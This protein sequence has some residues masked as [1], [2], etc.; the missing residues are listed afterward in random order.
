MTAEEHA[1]QAKHLAIHAGSIYQEINA[2]VGAN[3]L[4]PH[5]LAVKFAEMQAVS[6]LAQVHA[7]LAQVPACC[8]QHPDQPS[9]PQVESPGG[10]RVIPGPDE[11]A[12][13]LDKRY[14]PGSAH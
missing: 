11:S 10:A 14:G 7:T 6:T 12:R 5:E 2:Q 1:E 9:T 4:Q 8:S 13:L 3:R